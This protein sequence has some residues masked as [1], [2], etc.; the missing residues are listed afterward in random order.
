MHVFL[1]TA[2][3]RQVKDRDVRFGSDVCQRVSWTT[4]NQRTFMVLTSTIQTWKL[5]WSQITL[6]Y[7]TYYTWIIKQSVIVQLITLQCLSQQHLWPVQRCLT[8]L[9]FNADLCSTV[10]KFL[11]IMCHSIVKLFTD[12]TALKQTAQCT[13]FHKISILIRNLTLISILCT[14]KRP[15]L[16]YW[17]LMS[18]QHGNIVK[19]GCAL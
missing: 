3:G 16:I 14:K 19:Q 1:F 6:H 7:Y 12:F 2:N 18:R 10:H 8:K 13:D 5:M 15:V 11:N 9:V 17:L 4:F